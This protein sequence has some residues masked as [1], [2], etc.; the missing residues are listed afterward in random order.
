MDQIRIKRSEEEIYEVNISDDGKTI[1]FDLLDIDFPMRLNDA[2]NAIEKNRQV[3]LGNIQVIKNKKYKDNKKDL[4]NPKDLEINKEYKKMFIE[5]RKIL[6]GL[7]GEGT[8]QALF[9][10]R[11][12]LTMYDDMFD[13]LQP[14]FEKLNLTVDGIKN[15][16]EKK[17]GNKKSE[18][19]LV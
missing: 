17:Y 10:D 5:N 7:F 11:D 14:V 8:M 18:S 4:F 15:K 16:I 12:Y 19:P 9:G 2:Y 3:C 1:K 13:A 6:D